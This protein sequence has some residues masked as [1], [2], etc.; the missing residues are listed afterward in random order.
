M[1]DTENPGAWVLMNQ[2]PPR[3]WWNQDVP[4]AL[5]MMKK[6]AQGNTFS[7]NYPGTKVGAVVFAGM[8]PLALGYNHFPFK[9]TG[10]EPWMSV[11]E[12][13]LKRVVHAEVHAIS[14]LQRL[15][16]GA[17]IYTTQPPCAQCAAAILAAGIKRI[18]TE[19]PDAETQARWGAD[20]K[21][22]EDMVAA[23]GGEVIY[24]HLS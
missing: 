10:E 4:G 12:E 7:S 20:F 1:T 11:R 6:I 3:P 18:I 9:C 8:T 5:S 16:E 21:I 24:D 14:R 13:R 2:T 17:S 15:G 23:A 22:M 19:R